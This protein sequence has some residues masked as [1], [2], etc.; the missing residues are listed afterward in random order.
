MFIPEY[1]LSPC[2][3]EKSC[4]ALEPLL[5]ADVVHLLTP[6]PPLLLLVQLRGNPLLLLYKII[7]FVL[8]Q[9]VN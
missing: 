2:L 7:P 8:Y 9:A 1:I 5:G 4:E 3:T 6:L